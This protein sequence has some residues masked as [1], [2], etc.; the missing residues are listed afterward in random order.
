ME[1]SEGEEGAKGVA[2]EHDGK[3]DGSLHSNS[4][5]SAHLFPF[6]LILLFP[7]SFSRQLIVLNKQPS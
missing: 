6:R 7:S 1:A 4:S 5:F 2:K 3:K